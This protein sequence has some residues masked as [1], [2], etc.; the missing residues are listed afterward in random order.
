MNPLSFT[1]TE[2]GAAAAAATTGP[3]M[4]LLDPAQRIDDRN[5]EDR[6]EP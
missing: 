2:E 5:W 4:V 1:K 6:L 3:A